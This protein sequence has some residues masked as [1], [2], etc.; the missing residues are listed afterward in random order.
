MD[1]RENTI[2]KLSAEIIK[3]NEIISKL[4]VIKDTHV[5]TWLTL[6]I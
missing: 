2:K 4:Q 3:A 5:R 6:C 1:K